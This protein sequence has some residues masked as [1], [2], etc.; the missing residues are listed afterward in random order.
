LY[1]ITYNTRDAWAYCRG[2]YPRPGLVLNEIV[3]IAKAEQ[4]KPTRKCSSELFS[5]LSVMAGLGVGFWILNR[6]GHVR[7]LRPPPA[8]SRH[9]HSLEVTR[10]PSVPSL[11]ASSQSPY[12]LI[13]CLRVE[14][15]SS[16]GPS[17]R[18]LYS[19]QKIT[20]RMDSSDSAPLHHTADE[21]GI[22]FSVLFFPGPC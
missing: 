11:C 1:L 3:S 9:R 10:S 22:G 13:L 2:Q 15:H 8:E 20:P 21:A 17:L 4:D 6:S 5:Y 16:P 7:W 19:I 18:C 12:I 14:S